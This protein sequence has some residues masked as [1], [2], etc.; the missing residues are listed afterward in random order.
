MVPI[1]VAAISSNEAYSAGEI[2]VLAGACAGALVG[3]SGSASSPFAIALAYLAGALTG[4]LLP[5]LLVKCATL[6]VL[7]TAST[8]VAVGGSSLIA[9]SFAALLNEIVN[10]LLYT[11]W[12]NAHSLIDGIVGLFVDFHPSGIFLIAFGG[13]AG[14]AVGYLTSWGSEKGYYHAV[15]LPL[16]AWEMQRGEA[17]ILGAF[18]LTCLCLP[19]AGICAAVW[20][21]SALP[22]SENNSMKRHGRLVRKGFYSNILFGDFVEA[23]YPFSVPEMSDAGVF[24]PSVAMAVRISCVLAGAVLGVSWGWDL[25]G[26]VVDGDSQ[27]FNEYLWWLQE[28]VTGGPV[29][30][31]AYLPLPLSIGLSLWSGGGW[32]N[33]LKLSIAGLISFA[34]PFF[35]ALIAFSYR[36]KR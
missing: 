35:T 20:L 32:A 16:I 13:L 5:K 21:L 23:C 29:R 8:I 19:C 17:S 30:S 27:C 18:D 22:S 4:H 28:A 10:S 3:S 14:G 24:S 6:S 7:P 34:G 15:M 26:T 36:V 1:A 2:S 9:G 25:M 11:Y 12:N 31:S 33:A